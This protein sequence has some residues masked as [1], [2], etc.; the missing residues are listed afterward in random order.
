MIRRRPTLCGLVRGLLARLARR[1]GSPDPVA[2]A[3][4]IAA[5]CRGEI[6]VDEAMRRVLAL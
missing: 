4:I 1:A 6:T 3:R 5:A 2:E